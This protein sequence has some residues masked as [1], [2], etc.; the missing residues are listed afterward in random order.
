MLEE[1]NQCLW[2]GP[3]CSI[4]CRTPW[5]ALVPRY[6]HNHCTTIHLDCFFVVIQDIETMNQDAGRIKQGKGLSRLAAA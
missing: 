2:Q 4:V 5:F 1:C 3:Y 6:F